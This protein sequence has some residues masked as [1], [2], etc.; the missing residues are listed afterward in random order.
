MLKS[1]AVDLSLLWNTAVRPYHPCFGGHMTKKNPIGRSNG[2]YSS[3]D[4]QLSFDRQ[5]GT[6]ER[7]VSLTSGTDEQ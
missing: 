2:D 6:C 3:V 4:S 5:I 1:E 7:A